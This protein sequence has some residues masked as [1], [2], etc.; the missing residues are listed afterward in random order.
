[1]ANSDNVTCSGIANNVEVAVGGDVFSTDC[2]VMPLDT[3]DVVL[4]VQWLLS[5]GPILWD[6]TNKR[7]SFHHSSELTIWSNIDAAA[8]EEPHTQVYT[9]LQLQGELFTAPSSLPLLIHGRVIPLPPK[10]F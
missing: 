7:I 1:M 4:G 6:F 5:L 8:S 10:E 3:C 9:G 2:F